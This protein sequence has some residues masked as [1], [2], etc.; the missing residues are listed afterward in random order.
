MN[1]IV[2]C[3]QLKKTMR[4]RITLLLLL[5]YS[6]LYAQLGSWAPN[7]LN[8]HPGDERTIPVQRYSDE[9]DLYYLLS[10]DSTSASSY[11]LDTLSLFGGNW[12]LLD[13]SIQAHD[14]VVADNGDL[15]F[16]KFTAGQIELFATN[17]DMLPLWSDSPNG[18]TFPASTSFELKLFKG[19]NDDYYVSAMRGGTEITYSY[20]NGVWDSIG[21]Y[22][23]RIEFL[24]NGEPVK[25]DFASYPTH[26]SHAFSRFDGNN[27][28]FIDSATFAPNTV[29]DY[30]FCVSN[31][32]SIYFSHIITSLLWGDMSTYVLDG[33][34]ALIGSQIS[35]AGLI[36][37][38]LDSDL[39]GDVHLFYHACDLGGNW[40][41][42]I[43]Y[44]AST[45]SPYNGISTL[46]DGDPSGEAIRPFTTS[47]DELNCIGFAFG[48]HADL[49][50]TNGPDTISVNTLKFC[51]CRYT[52]HENTLSVQENT[53][54]SNIIE[55]AT[56]QWLDCDNNFAA[57]PGATNATFSP[58]NNGS[59]ALEVNFNGCTDTSDCISVSTIGLGEINET[60]GIHCYPNPTKDHLTISRS[61]DETMN[62]SLLDMNGK[63]LQGWEKQSEEFTLNLSHLSSGIYT[64]Q[65]QTASFV[66]TM[67]IR[68]E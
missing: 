48:E 23:E 20:Q 13:A 62:I 36:F 10:A 9:N 40:F 38:R 17:A 28:V 27:W 46:M 3:N 2:C 30:D 7:G 12:G 8:L 33:G 24:S 21:G 63:Y 55:H 19:F 29:I 64:L 66:R 67:K 18:P 58:I 68:K 22:I 1:Y 6:H 43:P 52:Q 44:C 37:L 65:L 57:I 34:P 47:V 4:L 14:F 45:R 61:G 26:Y 53:I 31:K 32:D 56:Y 25:M 60:Y 51:N 49:Y 41:N 50:Q 54:V 39:M 35:E 11:R 59:Y 16:T 42:H 15:I 5:S